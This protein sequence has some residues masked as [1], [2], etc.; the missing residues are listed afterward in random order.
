MDQVAKLDSQA[1]IKMKVYGIFGQLDL[2]T[3]PYLILIEKASLIGCILNCQILKIDKLLYLPIQEAENPTSIPSQDQQ[4]IQMLEHLQR[5][6]AFYFSYSFDLTKRLERTLT[7][8]IELNQS[9]VR[10]SSNS[11][12]N[13]PDLINMFPNSINYISKFAFNHNMLAE[14]K[15]NQYAPFRTPVIYGFVSIH[16]INQKLDFI[17]VS[18]K[19]CRRP[20]RRFLVRGLDADGNAANFCETEHIISFKKDEHTMV[21]SHLQIRGSIPLLWQMKPNMKYT[22]P[23][24][25]D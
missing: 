2:A 4:F 1:T 15:D 22:P 19:D 23:V 12:V 20:G 3:G 10:R 6:Q 13:L 5:D 14:F 7:E 9:G 8:T 25:I 16:K 11:G 24:T 17:L 21:A 18:R